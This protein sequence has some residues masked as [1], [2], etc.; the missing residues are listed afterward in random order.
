MFITFE[1]IDFC[2]KTTQVRLLEKYFTDSGREVLV[3]REP[4]GTVISEQ[5]REVLLSKKYSGMFSTTEI[6]LFSASRAQLV[7]EV[8]EP[9]LSQNKIVIL[10]RFYDSTTAYQGNGRGLSLEEVNFIN[11]MA[12]Q[13]TIPNITFFLDI[14]IEEMLVRKNKR[15]SDELDRI[16][17]SDFN[18]FIKVRDAYITLSNIESNRFFRINA[19]QPV[20]VVHRII[21]DQVK[22]IKL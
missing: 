9:A 12:V 10:D 1:G 16:E 4:G 5:I 6:L 14:S 22:R 11:K 15:N 19:E 21:I 2:G 8:I 18:F 20:E 17:E 7:R 3:L 13:N